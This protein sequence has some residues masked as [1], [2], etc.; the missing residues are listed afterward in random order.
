MI[1]LS[2]KLEITEYMS[3]ADAWYFKVHGDGTVTR[4]LAPVSKHIEPRV[5]RL[6]LEW[7]FHGYEDRSRFKSITKEEYDKQESITIKFITNG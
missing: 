4:L 7:A 6:H 1:T 3:W 2:D 5:A